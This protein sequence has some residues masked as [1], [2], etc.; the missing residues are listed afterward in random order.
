[1]FKKPKEEQPLVEFYTK[2]KGLIDTPE[3]HP[4]P[5]NKFLP[6]W[7]RDMPKQEPYPAPQTIKI[8]PSFPDFFSQGYIIPLWTDIILNYDPLT[9]EYHWNAGTPGTNNPFVVEGHQNTQ[10]VNYVTPS[11]RGMP[12]QFVF[13]FISPWYLK[14]PDG[15]SVY[16]MPLFYHFDNRFSVLPGI[17]HTDIHTQINQQVLYHGTGESIVIKRGTPFVQYIPFK[18]QKYQVDIRQMNTEDDKYDSI[19]SYNL[20]SKFPGSGAYKLKFLQH[21][22]GLNVKN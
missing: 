13:K 14:T 10:F 20:M 17:I 5:A 15:Y 4:Q 1:L 16:Q 6:Q 3:L 8:C 22:K 7:W 12:G 11:F 2:V 9:S 21:E 19:E 18:R